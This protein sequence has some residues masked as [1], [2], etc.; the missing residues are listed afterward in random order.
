MKLSKVLIVLIAVLFCLLVVQINRYDDLSSQSQYITTQGTNLEESNDS[1]RLSNV[2]STITNSPKTVNYIIL[3][4]VI[5]V[6][7]LAASVL[8][9]PRK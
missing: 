4:L 3:G 1:N 8:F 5:C 9:E 7:A 2:L 6:I